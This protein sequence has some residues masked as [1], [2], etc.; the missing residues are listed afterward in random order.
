LTGDDAVKRVFPQRE[1][2]AAESTTTTT[3][4]TNTTYIYIHTRVS[5]RGKKKEH[6]EII[7]KEK[8]IE[9]CW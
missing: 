3:T 6:N 8:G 1:K 2:K 5:E 9:Q 4:T 7:W